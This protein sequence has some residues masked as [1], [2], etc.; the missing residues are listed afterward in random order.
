MEV[1]RN[2]CDF[3]KHTV[4]DSSIVVHGIGNEQKALSLTVFLGFLFGQISS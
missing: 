4:G 3:A 2:L 1:K